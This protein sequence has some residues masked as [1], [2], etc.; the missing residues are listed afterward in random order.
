MGQHRTE[1]GYP[2][3]RGA[4]VL[5]STVRGTSRVPDLQKIRGSRVLLGFQYALRLFIA[6][7][8]FK[9]RLLDPN[10][11]SQIRINSDTKKNSMTPRS[12]VADH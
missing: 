6:L 10:F 5:R 7:N 1:A 4:G 9:P 12:A 2:P 11:L 3:S 8:H